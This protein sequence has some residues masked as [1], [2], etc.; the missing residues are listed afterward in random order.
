V[1]LSGGVTGQEHV[2]LHRDIRSPGGNQPRHPG[3]GR[4]VNLPEIGEPSGEPVQQTTQIHTIAAAGNDADT[5]AD[6]DSD[7]DS[8]TDTDEGGE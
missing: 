1:R 7:T 5:D 4:A 2:T 3:D 8:D 6:T